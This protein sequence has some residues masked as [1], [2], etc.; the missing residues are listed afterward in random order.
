MGLWV[1]P[2]VPSDF[3]YLR[4]SEFKTPESSLVLGLVLSVGR[5]DSAATITILPDWAC[6]VSQKVPG[7]STLSP[8]CQKMLSTLSYLLTWG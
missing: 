7:L 3:W 5:D 2:V 4:N 8:H 6:S 1:L